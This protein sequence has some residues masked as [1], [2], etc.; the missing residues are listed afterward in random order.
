MS[1]MI[2]CSG[3]ACV[4]CQMHT[5]DYIIL[6]GKTYSDN[7]GLDGRIVLRKTIRK[8]TVFNWL[9]IRSIGGK[10]ER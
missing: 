4:R 8:I 5:Q 9:S 2:R 1:K 3:F 10:K 7:R 6:F